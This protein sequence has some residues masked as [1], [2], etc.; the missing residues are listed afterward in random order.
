MSNPDSFIDEVTEEV[1]RDRLL[2]RDAPVGV[3]RGAADPRPP[4]AERS[5]RS[6]RGRATGPR[7]RRFGDALLTALSGDDIAARRASLADVVPQDEEQRA[8]LS[9]IR[10]AAVQTGAEA[11]PEAARDELLALSE[12]AGLD[13]TYRHLAVLKAMLAGGTG[14]ATRDTA[15][16]EE[17]RPARRALPHARGRAAALATLDAGDEERRRSRSCAC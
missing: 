8:I 4:W 2:R 11:D 13:P 5:G 7:R 14:D 9:L 1:R 12:T 15:L 16:A 17:A 6:G 10:A 3:G